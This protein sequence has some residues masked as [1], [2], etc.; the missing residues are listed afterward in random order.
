MDIEIIKAFTNLHIVA[1]ALRNDVIREK[2]AYEADPQI[3]ELDKF[4]FHIKVFRIVLHS[5]ERQ[6]Q[7]LVARVGQ[8]V[9]SNQLHVKLEEVR[10]MI[11]EHWSSDMEERVERHRERQINQV[12]EELVIINTKENVVCAICLSHFQAA[13]E[14]SQL[15]CHEHHIFHKQCILQWLVKKNECPMCRRQVYQWVYWREVVGDEEIGTLKH[16]IILL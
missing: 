16:A 4:A 12:V 3:K 15:L 14:V 10:D 6:S 13:E 9:A 7:D 5:L 11:L 2:T 8:C 1:R